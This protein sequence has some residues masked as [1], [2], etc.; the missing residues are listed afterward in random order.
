MIDYIAARTNKEFFET[1]FGWNAKDHFEKEVTNLLALIDT[2]GEPPTIETRIQIIVA[3]TDAYI[4]QTGKI[5]EGVQIQRL[6]NWLLLEDLT[7]NHPDKVTRE[8]YPVLTK[9]QLRTRYR[10]ERADENIPETL[11]KQKYLGGKK[12]PTFT[13]SE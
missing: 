10:R 13:K 9:R 4:D 3:I 8:D 6:G 2:E 5:P 11:T 12:Q 7:N 1:K